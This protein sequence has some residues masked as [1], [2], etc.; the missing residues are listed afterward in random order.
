MLKAG[1]PEL[2]TLIDMKYIME[3]PEEGL[4]KLKQSVYKLKIK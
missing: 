1:K 3:L 2:L 4:I